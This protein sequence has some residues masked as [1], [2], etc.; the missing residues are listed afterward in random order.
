M[1]YQ[2]SCHCGAVKFEAEGEFKEGLSCNCSICQRKGT[3]LDFVPET[4][5]RLMSGA[6]SLTDYQFG[7]KNIHHTFCK[8]CGVSPFSSAKMPN[9]VAMKAI[10]LR[11]LENFS[12]E[13]LKIKHFDGKSL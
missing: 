4:S 7:K 3:I 9:G 5:F 13:G 2:G 12:V 10:N 8:T 11:C 6:D 1:K